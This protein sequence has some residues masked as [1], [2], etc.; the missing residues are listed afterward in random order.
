MKL[1]TKF[2][3]V[4]F[5]VSLFGLV[6]ESTKVHLILVR[7]EKCMLYGAHGT[8]PFY[9]RV[10]SFCSASSSTF[11][12]VK[13]G[14]CSLTT[15]IVNTRLSGAQAFD[16]RLPCFWSQNVKQLLLICMP[17]WSQQNVTINTLQ[18]AHARDIWLLKYN[19]SFSR[20][21]LHSNIEKNEREFR[22]LA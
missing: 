10:V 19:T 9:W 17:V 13:P 8:M 2:Y 18:S 4:K 22:V 7:C 12:F 6:F 20:S 3:Y 5:Q 15:R 16:K 14:E 21:P 1:N 11:V